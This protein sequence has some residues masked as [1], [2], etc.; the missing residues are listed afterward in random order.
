M[1][2]SSVIFAAAVLAVPVLAQYRAEQTSDQ[3]IPVVRLIDEA[4]D[5]VVAVV[6][7]VGNTAYQMRVHGKDILWFPQTLPEY[8]ANPMMS[9]IPLLAPWGNRLDEQAFYAGEQKYNFDMGL[10]NV[11]GEHPIHG[12]LSFTPYW[13]VRT[14]TADSRSARYTARL[15]FW[16]YPDLMAQWPFAH[17]YE[18]VYELRNGQLEVRLI[19]TNRSDEVMPIAVGFHPY[20]TIPGVP[21][22][23]WM[24]H[25]PARNRVVTTPDL[26]PTGEFRPMDLGDENGEFTLRGRTLDDGFI[27]LERNDDR[28]AVFTIRAGDQEVETSF[29]QHYPVAIVWEPDDAQGNPRDFICIEPMAG[30]TDQLNLAAKGLAQQPQ[31]VAPGERWI[32]RFTVSTSGI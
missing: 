31:T 6:P 17:D 5:V 18:M 7:S 23:Q 4:N 3:G 21:R 11:T 27:D 1:R 15:E 12:L 32:G 19:V 24:V 9:G 26:I 13:E 14:V 16:R 30:M 22:D 28:L 25:I 20:Y 8:K 29:G 10:G 2:L